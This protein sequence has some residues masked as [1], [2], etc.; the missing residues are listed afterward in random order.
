MCSF[1]YEEKK[2]QTTLKHL[3]KTSPPPFPGSFWLQTLAVYRH[4]RLHS[5]PS[6]RQK[7]LQRDCGKAI[8]VCLQCS[9]FLFSSAPLLVL[10]RLQSLQ[11]Y[12]LCH[13]APPSV[14]TLVFLLLVLTPFCSLLI[15]PSSILFPFLNKLSQRHHQH[16]WWA[17]LCPVLRSLWSQLDQS[18]I[19][20]VQ[21]GAS[22]WLLIKATSAALSSPPTKTWLPLLN[23]T[24]KDELIEMTKQD[25]AINF[26]NNPELIGG[27]GL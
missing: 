17:Q 27:S 15:S 16:H 11:E 19:G 9:F 3:G 2:K 8:A 24:S 23:K 18:E 21:P 25:S 7:G 26:N 6:V 1:R 13:G 10:H 4:C 22:P 20:C 14:F 5:V 12:L